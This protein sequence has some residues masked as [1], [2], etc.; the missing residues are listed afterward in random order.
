MIF[1]NNFIKLA[2]L[3]ALFFLVALFFTVPKN[4]QNLTYLPPPVSIK[5]MTV[6]LKYQIADSLWIRAIQDFD[7]CEKKIS[8]NQCAGRSWLYQ[9]LNLIT[10]IDPVL[11]PDMYRSAGL[12]LTIII[13]DYEGASVIF[14]KAVVQY[15]KDWSLLYT[16]GYHAL[17]EE[18]NK[19]KASKLYF[20]AA[21][22]GAPNWVYAM[23]G[24]LASESGANDYSEKILQG[25][26]D[27]KVDEKIIKRL[28][29]RLLENK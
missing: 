23:A 8:E 9:L 29:S 2:F 15:P 12:A 18:K 16:A 3:P 24:R 1:K 5:N 22:N 21:Q 7:Y 13:S 10:E 14:D 28:R 17:F 27:L 25:M 20:A 19:L 4:T 26:I 6:G 11:S